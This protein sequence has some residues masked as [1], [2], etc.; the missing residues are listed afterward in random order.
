LVSQESLELKG[1]PDLA[2]EAMGAAGRWQNQALLLHE[3]LLLENPGIL[4]QLIGSR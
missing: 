1:Q 2:R 4:M 3:L